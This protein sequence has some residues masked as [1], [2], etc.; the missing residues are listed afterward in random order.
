MTGL[1][2]EIIAALRAAAT[3]HQNGDFAEIGAAYDRLSHQLGE[4][5]AVDPICG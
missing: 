5:S 4:F 1:R 2:T 3:A